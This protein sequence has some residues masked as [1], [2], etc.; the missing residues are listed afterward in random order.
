MF[1]FNAFVFILNS[2][3]TFR[4]CTHLD[5]KHSV[6]GKLVGGMDVLSK[7]EAVETDKKDRPKSS[8]TIEDC[9]VFVDPYQEVD[10][11]V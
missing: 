6:F 4:A 3:I 11:Q 9:I 7:M 10:E 5:N 8:I 2:F 1:H